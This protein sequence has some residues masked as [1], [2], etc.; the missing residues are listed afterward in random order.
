ME[1]PFQV[2]ETLSLEYLSESHAKETFALIEQNR[3][4]LKQWLTWLDYM[5]TEDI[6]RSFVKN[7]ETNREKGTD[8]AFAILEN[9]IITGRIG[10]YYIDNQNHT[11]NIGYWLDE[12]AQGS[13]IVTLCCK[14]LLKWGF[15]TLNLNR[16]EIRCAT[17]NL[18]SR[19]IPEKLGFK[20]EGILREAE[21]LNGVYTDLNLFSML[22]SEFKG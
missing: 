15:E 4:Y 2:N 16:I 3:S 20:F 11:G 1:F 13:G 12:K 10:I 18:K 5:A 14:T 7:A 19:A 21:L 6:F 8:Y 22:R 17:G 9:G